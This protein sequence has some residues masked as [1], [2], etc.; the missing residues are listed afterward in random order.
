MKHLAT[1]VTRERKVRY[2]LIAIATLFMAICGTH[3]T[4]V[5]YAS[6]TGQSLATHINTW[7]GPASPGTNDKVC[8]DTTCSTGPLAELRQTNA[9]SAYAEL[10]YHTWNIGVNW[11]KSSQTQWAWRIGQAVDKY[12]GTPRK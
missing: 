6:S 1:R 4:M 3:G 12:L 9:A 5:M 2:A 10:E 7:V 11:I 8:L